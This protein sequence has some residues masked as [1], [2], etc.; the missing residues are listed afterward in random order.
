MERAGAIPEAMRALGLPVERPVCE[1]LLAVAA[2]C[3]R[4][5]RA[6]EALAA[7]DD[8]GI[9]RD[10]ASYN[11]ALGMLA[12]TR[13]LQEVQ[14]CTV[15]PCFFPVFLEGRTRTARLTAPRVGP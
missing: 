9:A 5:H 6:R 2:G 4:L 15:G 1:G 14:P 11:L 3:N 10:T 8:F 13:R 12:R 7:Y